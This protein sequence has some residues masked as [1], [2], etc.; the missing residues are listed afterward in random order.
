MMGEYGR[1]IY[2]C[3]NN[4]V[5]ILYKANVITSSFQASLGQGEEVEG[6][7]VVRSLMVISSLFK[8]LGIRSC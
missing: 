6:R 1:Y 5:P 7:T 8:A 2:I 3:M 4:V